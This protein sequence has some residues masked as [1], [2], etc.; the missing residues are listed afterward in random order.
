MLLVQ[1]K[2][3]NLDF[4]FLGGGEEE[5]LGG[6]YTYKEEFTLAFLPQAICFNKSHWPKLRYTIGYNCDYP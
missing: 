2:F 6:Y 4:F 1:Y 5:G 3:Q